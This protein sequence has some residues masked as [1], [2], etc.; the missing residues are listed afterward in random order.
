MNK[1][2]EIFGQPFINFRNKERM[3]FILFTESTSLENRP[4]YPKPTCG[5]G[6]AFNTY[7]YACENRWINPN[8]VNYDYA[9]QDFSCNQSS[10]AV[11][12]DNA[13]Q[14]CAEINTIDTT[15]YTQIG[16]EKAYYNND[17]ISDFSVSDINVTYLAKVRASYAVCKSVQLQSHKSCEVIANYY[18]ST[19]FSESNKA[20]T[21]YTTLF[22]PSTK[23]GGLY[24]YS[25][26]LRGIPWVA[27][28]TSLS[29]VN[30]ND[31]ISTKFKYKDVL[32]FI[33]AK[34]DTDGNFLGYT[35]MT[36]NFVYC[37]GNNNVTQIWRV[38]GSDFQ[39]QCQL[40][41]TELNFQ[42]NHYMYEPFFLENSVLRP[43]PVMVSGA[44]TTRPYRRFFITAD[45]VSNNKIIYASDIGMT[46]TLREGTHDEILPPVFSIT[47]KSVPMTT[48]N[49]H[50][51][52][53]TVTYSESF[54]TFWRSVIIVSAVFGA[55]A[56]TYF[57]FKAFTYVQHFGEDGIDGKVIVGL[58]GEILHIVGVLLFFIVFV[59]S[60]YILCF[61]KWQKSL[62]MF[63]PDADDLYNLTIMQWTAFA[64]VFVSVVI[65]II[66]TARTDVFLIDWE[67]PREKNQPVSSWRRLMIS[68]EFVRL[69]TKRSYNIP[70][71]LIVMLFILTG[72]KTNLMA[73][74]VPFTLLV[75]LGIPY[76]I[77]TFAYT[78]FLWLIFMLAEWIFMTFVKWGIMGNP[79]TNFLDLCAM[80]N[81]SV[82]MMVSNSYGYYLHG[83]SVHVHADENMMALHDQLSQ[84]QEGNIGLRGLVP[85]TTDQ[86]FEIYLTQS[87]RAAFRQ[88]YDSVQSV[89]RPRALAGEK[90]IT[91]ASVSLEALQSYDHLNAFLQKFINDEG[92]YEV[93]PAP[94]S[95]V[96]LGIAPAVQEKSVFLIEK[97]IM[98][99]NSMLA[100]I[101][102]TLMI[103][104]VLLFCGI[105]TQTNSPPIAA[106]VTFLVDLFI[107][108][109]TQTRGKSNIA[110]KS[111][112]DN[113]FIIS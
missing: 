44:S 99:K 84:E 8:N 54:T 66:Q 100:G 113:R 34:Y 50:A 101:E 94:F 53:F 41:I 74:P 35:K 78:A 51:F 107:V 68:N 43:I 13:A 10:Q 77:L 109:V 18:A 11:L 106:F 90:N 79:F 2:D 22:S 105:E 73:S 86:V 92:Q 39:S 32:T 103:F 111:L 91:W 23:T 26:W 5:D 28:P 21:T 19:G 45:Y 17:L 40:N 56:F 88:T 80:A 58:F 57:L 110:K 30:D 14:S 42:D 96:F 6:T 36:D 82:I 4:V 70:F 3:L 87:F 9:T 47:Y 61:F 29:Q 7:T 46:I 65:K 93:K 102:W 33:L 75:D 67:T 62:F 25:Y 55:L 1:S 98:F 37:G 83:R 24:G 72:F 20:Y 108:K 48:T 49:L 89:V 112:I 59:F 15:K 63:L 76:K 71:T 38:I 85:G 97:D 31:L 95:Q 104:Y 81:C 27:Y 16:S 60:F 64:C 12:F 52:N 69:F